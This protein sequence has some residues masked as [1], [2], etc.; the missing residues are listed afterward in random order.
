MES[1]LESRIHL[2]AGRGHVIPTPPSLEAYRRMTI[3]GRQ[4]STSSMLKSVR[5]TRGKAKQFLLLERI[6]ERTR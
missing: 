5:L 3:P 6:N 2:S 4:E 1:N